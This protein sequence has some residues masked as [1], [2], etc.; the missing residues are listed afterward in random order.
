[1]ERNDMN[2]FNW[3]EEQ[4]REFKQAF[5]AVPFLLVVYFLI[6]LVC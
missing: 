6:C 4:M 1:M 2:P 3:D 5:I